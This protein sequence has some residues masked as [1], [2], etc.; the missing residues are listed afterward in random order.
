MQANHFHAKCQDFPKLDNRIQS[1]TYQSHFITEVQYLSITV[2]ETEG[3]VQDWN[4][5]TLAGM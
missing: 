3:V 5:N 1:S 4:T 2:K